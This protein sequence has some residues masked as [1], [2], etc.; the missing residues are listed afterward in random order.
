MR[1]INKIKSLH[2]DK[3]GKLQVLIDGEPIDLIDVKSMD[4]HIEAGCVS[5]RIEKIRHLKFADNDT[6]KDGHMPVARNLKYGA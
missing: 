5:L 6:A 1:E 2:I 3:N 4:I